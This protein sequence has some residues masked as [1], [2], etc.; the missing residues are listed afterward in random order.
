MTKAAP[1]ITDATSK[2]KGANDYD[3][4][5]R[6]ARGYT[7]KVRVIDKSPT[8]S[9]LTFEITGSWADDKTGKARLFDNATPFIV[10]PH[11]LSVQSGTE[12]DLEE[13]LETARV[14]MVERVSLTAANYFAKQSLLGVK[15]KN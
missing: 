11:E 15:L 7:V 13:L 3:R 5:Y 14:L 4:I 12:V 10:D 8:P 6:C 1:H 9:A 2:F